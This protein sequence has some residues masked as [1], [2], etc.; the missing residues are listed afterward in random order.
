MFDKIKEYLAKPG[1]DVVSGAKKNVDEATVLEVGLQL[2][3]DDAIEKLKPSFFR[4]VK[5]LDGRISRNVVSKA[6]DVLEDRGFVSR[7]AGTKFQYA[8]TE[9][10]AYSLRPIYEKVIRA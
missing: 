4:L 2:Y 5:T 10:G 8:L 3:Y 6:L 7:N 9:C 1:I